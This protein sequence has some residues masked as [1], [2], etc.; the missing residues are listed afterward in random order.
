MLGSP[1]VPGSCHVVII[2]FVGGGGVFRLFV[3]NLPMDFPST[4][5][6]DLLRH[7]CS[8]SEPQP[9]SWVSKPLTGRS[10]S[11]RSKDLIS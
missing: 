5:V 6:L 8:S 2:L 11:S 9:R 1:S 4:P 3:L 10:M 7:H